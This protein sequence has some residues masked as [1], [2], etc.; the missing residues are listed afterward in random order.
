MAIYSP[1]GSCFDYWGDNMK[2]TN[3]K[4]VL[5]PMLTFAGF[6]PINKYILSIFLIV[7]VFVSISYSS[8]CRRHENLFLF[9]LVPWITIPMNIIC[10]EYICKNMDF[11]WEDISLLK[12]LILPISYCMILSFEEI[13]LGIIGRKIWNHRQCSFWR[14]SHGYGRSNKYY[15][16]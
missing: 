3:T 7:I 13:V 4:L 11:M 8:A 6:F 9:I 2:K 16:R 5:G 14:L 12:Y 1:F 15:Y 10:M